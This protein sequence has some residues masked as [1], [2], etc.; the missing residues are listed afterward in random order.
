M[1][2]I[3]TLSFIYRSS[4]KLAC[5]CG[6]DV[7]VCVVDDLLVNGSNFLEATLTNVI[8]TA[9]CEGCDLY[10]YYLDYDESQL[11]DP[12][13]VINSFDI[14]GFFCSGCLVAYLKYLIA[15]ALAPT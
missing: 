15:L 2:Q 7:I 5:E 1:R 14:T 4:Q 6:G 8:T 12:T 9:D 13:Y 3:R 10:N 11:T